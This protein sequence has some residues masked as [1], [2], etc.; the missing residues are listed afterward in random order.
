[1]SI[2][3]TQNVITVALP[4]SVMN[5]QNANSMC[6]G[7][8]VQ[9][10]FCDDEWALERWE[11]T[12]LSQQNLQS[13]ILA[14]LHFITNYVLCGQHPPSL[15]TTIKYHKGNIVQYLF[16]IC[17]IQVHFLAYNRLLYIYGN[18]IVGNKCNSNSIVDTGGVDFH[19]YIPWFQL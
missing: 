2:E 19:V 13:K 10:T 7:G 3:T 11:D 17:H 4:T 14:S 5:T 16:S 6:Q 15:N 18:M 8:I 9:V 1:M 12:T